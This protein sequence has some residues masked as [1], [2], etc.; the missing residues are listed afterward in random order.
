MPGHASRVGVIRE[1]AEAAGECLV[2]RVA[3]ALIAEEN[4]LVAEQRVLD[5]G[6]RVVT[7]IGDIDAADFR[8]HGG[9]EWDRFDVPV[10]CGGVVEAF[11]RMKLH[12]ARVWLPNEQLLCDQRNG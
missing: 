3:N 9:G 4:H 7:E 1:W 10:T 11:V 12:G 2:L 5:F 8:P 6:E